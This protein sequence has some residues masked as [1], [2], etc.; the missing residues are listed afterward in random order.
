[1]STRF[2]PFEELTFPDVAALPRDLP[3][4][5]PLGS[6]YDQSELAAILGN[7]LQAAE[8]MIVAAGGEEVRA[9]DAIIARQLPWWMAKPSMS[10]AGE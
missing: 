3:L 10:R 9:E 5:L 2:F 7:P 6:D 4:I 8:A 1:M